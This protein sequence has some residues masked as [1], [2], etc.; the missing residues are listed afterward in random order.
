MDGVIVVA[1]EAEVDAELAHRIAEYS[2]TDRG[3]V[4]RGGSHQLGGRLGDQLIQRAGHVKYGSR[5]KA[6][7]VY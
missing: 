2:F 7:I 6:D 4:V 5:F 1:Q 3:V